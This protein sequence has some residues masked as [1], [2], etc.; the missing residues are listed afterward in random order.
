MNSYATDSVLIT[1]AGGFIGSHLA[2]RLTA[3]GASV[4]ALV[5]PGSDLWRIHDMPG[6]RL[7]P[8]DLADAEAVRRCIVDVR[9]KKTFHLA[10]V[11]NVDREPKLNLRMI[12]VNLKGLI[13]IVNALEDEEIDFDCLVNCGTCEEYGDNPAPFHERQRENPVSP[14]SASK[15]AATHFCGMLHKTRGLP[16]L[17]VRPFLTYGPRQTNHMLIPSLIR[18]CLA[19]EN[20]D[21]TPGEQT[22]E[23]NYVDD[24]VDG[25]L[26]AGRTP[27][28]IG[29]VINLGSG[30]EHRIRYV[31]ELV[32]DLT[33][34][35]SQ[36]NFGRI[37][38]RPGETM[39]FYSDSNLAREIL[40]WES[41]T[42]LSAGI[43]KTITWYRQYLTRP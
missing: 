33:N 20:F 3:V 12:D 16:L 15:V 32:R 39:H 6:L 8:V 21:M 11:T 7:M 18:R 23:F 14:Y 13:H 1:G 9:P 42:E 43:E 22:R 30:K 36:L 40:G 4:T 35:K 17:T 38:Y 25:F 29:R 28:A 10:S 34:S 5:R 41:K 37:S 27:A 26:A 31:A 24:I 19:A 2:E